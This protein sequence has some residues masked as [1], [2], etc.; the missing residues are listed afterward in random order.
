MSA[1]RGGAGDE[2]T[3]AT[4]SILPENENY[5]PMQEG[6]QLYYRADEE[7]PGKIPL[8]S[9]LL[10]SSYREEEEKELSLSHWMGM[11]GVEER[12]LNA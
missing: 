4:A 1:S 9:S 10:P 6:K 3:L 11:R 8:G 2:D 5:L 12:P 7:D